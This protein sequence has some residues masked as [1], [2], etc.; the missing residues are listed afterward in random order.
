MSNLDK[1]EIDRRASVIVNDWAGIFAPYEAF[2]IHSILYSSSRVIESF[3]RYDIARSIGDTDINQV[4]AVHEVINHSASLSRFFWPS[5][6]RKSSSDQL[7]KLTEA[8]ASKLR[9]AFN[10]TN[11]S[12]LK[13]RNI[14][15]SLEHFD[16]RLDLYLLPNDSGYFFPT[17]IIGNADL[18]S[19]SLGHIFKLVDPK[20]STFVCLGVPYQ[21]GTLRK[22]AIRVH[23]LAQKMD[24]NGC[25]LTIKQ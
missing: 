7:K 16:E 4:S 6:L 8:R 22:E 14:R 17:P 5:A 21:F 3:Q 11:D 12:P 2:Y 25:R 23:S 15:D 19:D 10:M 1:S 13:N 9:E 24:E 20:T 18:A